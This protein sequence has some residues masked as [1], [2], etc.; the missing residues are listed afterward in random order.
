MSSLVALVPRR[1]GEG[2][3]ANWIF[4]RNVELRVC[5]REAVLRTE[6]GVP[7]LAPEL[8]LLFKSKDVRAKDEFDAHQVIPNLE[9]TRRNRLAE[10]L[11][12][13]HPWR[14]LRGE[15]SPTPMR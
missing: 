2:D 11:P 12:P 15:T 9:R 4:R 13:D 14:A 5:W 8:Q 6:Q 3:D 7:Y 1:D 10:W